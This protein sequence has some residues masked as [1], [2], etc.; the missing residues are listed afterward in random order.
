MKKQNPSMMSG[1]WVISSQRKSTKR[2]G[3]EYSNL[4]NLE[5]ENLKES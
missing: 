1:G 2:D 4:S 5:P 3:T